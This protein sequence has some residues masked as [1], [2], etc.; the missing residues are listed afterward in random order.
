MDLTKLS[1]SLFETLELLKEENE[2]IAQEEGL[3]PNRFTGKMF[4]FEENN[5]TWFEIADE[6]NTTCLISVD[7][8]NRTAWNEIAVV[9]DDEDHARKFGTDGY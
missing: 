1:T 8:P 9:A 2:R 7:F 4:F 5:S 6:F 3:S